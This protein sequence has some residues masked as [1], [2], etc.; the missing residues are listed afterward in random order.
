LA[1]AYG[2]KRDF[3]NAL[4]VADHILAV[5]PSNTNAIWLK[6]SL[7]W[8]MGNLDGAD[9]FL[10]SINAPVHLRGHQAFNKH[11]YAAAI[12]LFSKALAEK[13]TAD[14]KR[15]LLLDM[16]MVQQRAGNIVASKAAYQKAA[17]EFT[18]ALSTVS[19]DVGTDLHWGLGMSYAGLGDA[20]RAVAEGKKG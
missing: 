6:T 2:A 18:R 7:F 3:P 15:G 5:E 4:A 1:T 8:G 9:Q 13:P 10:A 14:E 20:T 11:Q 17:Q 12:D 19:T 16:G